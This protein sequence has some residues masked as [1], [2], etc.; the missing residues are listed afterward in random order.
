NL[1]SRQRGIGGCMFDFK[2]NLEIF[3][4]VLLILFVALGTFTPA[5]RADAQ[6]QP[7]L[8]AESQ[9][10]ISSSLTIGA[11][12]PF[13]SQPVPILEE[14]IAQQAPDEEQPLRIEL[15][16][17]PA[18]YSPGKPVILSWRLTGGNLEQRS[19]LS[20]I[21]RPPDGVLPVNEKDVPETDGSL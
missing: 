2:R 21:A 6:E 12:S 18:L 10:D 17:E 19:N 5:Q 13:P 14:Q 15:S 8:P 4:R 9:E 16:A 3:A 11:S 20:I 7:A 1:I